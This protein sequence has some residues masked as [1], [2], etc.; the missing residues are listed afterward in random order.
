MGKKLIERKNYY[1]PKEIAEIN[2]ISLQRV[3]SAY[4]SGKIFGIKLLGDRGGIRLHESSLAILREE[5][6]RD[7]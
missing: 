5:G 2:K 6:K 1:T 4:D 7:E 3:Y